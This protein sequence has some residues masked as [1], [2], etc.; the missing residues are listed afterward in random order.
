[1]GIRMNAP[2]QLRIDDLIELEALLEAS[3]LQ[4]NAIESDAEP[5]A[6]VNQPTDKNDKND[7][8]SH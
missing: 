7:L 8:A 5:T 1:M 3:N 6:G 2:L 4:V